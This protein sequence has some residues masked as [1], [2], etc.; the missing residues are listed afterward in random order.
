MID[1]IS[2]TDVITTVMIVITTVMIVITT[3][4]I[5]ITTVDR[6]SKRNISTNHLLYV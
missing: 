5:V 2:K 4:M 6:I 1:K 3:V